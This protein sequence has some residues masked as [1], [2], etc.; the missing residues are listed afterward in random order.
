M[1]S[2]WEEYVLPHR[3]QHGRFPGNESVAYKH[4]FL[5]RPVVNEYAELLW[6][7]LQ[8]AGFKGERKQRTF[9]VVPTH[10]V[11]DLLFWNAA[12]KKRWY[13][14]LAGDLLKRRNPRLAAKRRRSYADTMTDVKKDPYY[15]YDQL[16]DKAEKAGVQAQFYFM[17]GGHTTY[18]RPYDLNSALFREVTTQIK[19]RGH[20]IGYHGSYNT[21]NDP[22]L[23]L[24]EK[25]ALEQ[26]VER[27][28][29]SCRQH[30]LRF[31]V[32]ATWQVQEAAGIHTD[33]TLYYSG[34]PG[35]R[36]GSCYPFPVFD[37]LN[38]KQLQLIEKPLLLMDGDLG[39]PGPQQ[40]DQLIT[41]IQQQVKKFKGDF[42][43]LRHNGS[44]AWM[45]N[46]H[47]LNNYEKALYE[48]K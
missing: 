23:F 4:G 45:N 43:F 1:L 13:R 29:T 2:R 10:D 18:D 21:W 7:L 28:I 17:A 48:A 32:P 26:A 19:A 25:K 24:K 36:C 14:H 44:D 47:P 8:K 12:N 38:R 31:E 33:S 5:Y 20:L 39:K 11:D 37:I 22:A 6:L 16:M 9:S 40:A 30:Y 3:D 41:N 27:E 46:H 35:F 34:F 15:L 42:V